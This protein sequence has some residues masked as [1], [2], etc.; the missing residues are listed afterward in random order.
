MLGFATDAEIAEAEADLVMAEARLEYAETRYEIL[1]DGP[2]PDE[3]ELAESRVANAEAQ[4]AAAEAD[5]A[6]LEADQQEPPTQLNAPFTGTITELMIQKGEMINAGRVVIVLADFSSWYVETDD[7]TEINVV[8]VY[9]GEKAT[10]V[11]DAIPEVEMIGLV[12][13]ISNVYEEKQG[14]VTYTARI[15][16][17]DIDPRLRWGMTVVV[18][19]QEP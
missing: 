10:I 3:I 16:V 18:A 4:L 13:S 1:K 15:Q 7:L 9:D 6:D 2:D 11:A 8:H 12:A 14:D 19:F 17:D 5:L